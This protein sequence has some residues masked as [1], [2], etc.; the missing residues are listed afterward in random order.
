MSEKEGF[1][2]IGEKL[3]YHQQNGGRARNTQSVPRGDSRGDGPGRDS[4]L[5]QPKQT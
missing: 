5:H 4:D 3:L 2:G 1:S